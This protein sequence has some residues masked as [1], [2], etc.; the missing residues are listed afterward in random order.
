MT[1]DP[2]TRKIVVAEVMRE[3]VLDV[4]L[5]VVVTVTVSVEEEK[6]VC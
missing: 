4:D 6:E 2:A 3:A 1:V 5:S